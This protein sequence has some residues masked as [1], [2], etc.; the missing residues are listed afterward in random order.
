MIA[1]Y[2]FIFVIINYRFNDN[3][4]INYTK[5]SNKFKSK[6]RLTKNELMKKIVRVQPKLIKNLTFKFFFDFI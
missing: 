3:K 5:N 4:K 1:E 6:F 2:I